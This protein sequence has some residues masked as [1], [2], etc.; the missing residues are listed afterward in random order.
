[1]RTTIGLLTL[2]GSLVLAGFAHAECASDSSDEGVRKCLTQD[3]RDSD[4]RINAVYKLL[5]G[6]LEDGSKVSLR[7]EQRAWLKARDKAC[8]L[9]SKE[10]DREKWL[11]SI[12]VDQEKT[13]CVVRHTFARVAQ[14]DQ[15]LMQK[16]PTKSAEAP[17]APAAPQLSPIPSSPSGANA[18][19]V[20]MVFQDDGYKTRTANSHDRGRW[21]V[22]VSIDRGHIA[23]LGDIL[24]APGFYSAKSGVLRMVNVRRTQAGMAAIV[25]GL[26]LDLND[27]FAYI[28]QDGQ[29]RVPPGQTGSTSIPANIAYTAGID[30][31]SEVKELMRRGLVKVNIGQQPFLF[32][33]PP[34]YRAWGEI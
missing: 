13:V 19:P 32:P 15:L 34:G 24:L 3:L 23:D 8:S 27:G 17:A 10:S 1:M 6:S 21:Y 4:K 29:W 31:S 25:L 28:H 22:E 9:N 2:I 12:L 33:I 5:M 30:G 20:H 14:L 26:A 7:D 18:L 16:A 11:Q